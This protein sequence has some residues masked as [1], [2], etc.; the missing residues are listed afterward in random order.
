MKATLD[1]IEDGNATLSIEVDA[2]TVEEALGQAYRKIG[3]GKQIPGF[4][5]GKAPRAILENHVEP[6]EALKEALNTILPT[7]Y[8]DAVRSVGIEPIDAPRIKIESMEQGGPLTFTA[9][10]EIKPEINLNNY[11]TIAFSR[12]VPEVRPQDVDEYLEYLRQSRAKLFPEESG[13]VAP[14]LAVKV[15]YRAIL[16]DGEPVAETPDGK[17]EEEQGREVMIDV[18]SGEWDPMIEEQLIGAKVGDELEVRMV[19][20]EDSAKEHLAGKDVV[21]KTRILE[22]NRKEVP[23]LDDA[24][25]REVAKLDSLEELRADAE[26]KIRNAVEKRADTLVAQQAL[27]EAVERARVDIPE[28]MI[29]KRLQELVRQLSAE[30]GHSNPLQEDLF[31]REGVTTENFKERLRSRAM[32][33]VKTNLVI[34]ELVKQEAITVDDEEIQGTLDKSGLPP[35]ARDYVAETLVREKAIAFLRDMAV[36]NAAAKAAEGSGVRV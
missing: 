3:M 7:A 11:Q 30:L 32:Q 10:V 26:N 36:R 6:G 9:E 34:G 12:E 19:T 31:F 13:V 2:S 20:P 16:I 28:I 35:E 15:W 14:G 4:R 22:V 23:A 5:K 17:Q 1:K 29:E 33:D 21:F 24:F 8:N 25:A 27:E 18:G